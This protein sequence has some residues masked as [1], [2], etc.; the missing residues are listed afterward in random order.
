[1]ASPKLLN[2]ALV[3]LAALCFVAAPA[4]A[5]SGALRLTSLAVLASVRFSAPQS[6]APSNAQ[7]THPAHAPRSTSAF[8]PLENWKAAVL[9]GDSASLS[10]MYVAASGIF[11]KTPQ[12]TSDDP[13]EEP[14]FWSRFHSLGLTAIDAK[15][16]ERTTPQAGVIVLTMRVYLTFG[17]GPKATEMFVS[18]GQVWVQKDNAWYIFGSQRGDPVPRPILSLPE[19]ATPNTNLYP[20]PAEAPKDLAAA[21]AAAARDHKNVLVVFGGNWCFDCHV[22]DAAFHSPKIAPLVTANYHV[23]HINIGD[24]D[25]NMDIG[26]RY[27][28]PLK[29]GVP[30]VAVLDSKGK[31]LTSQQNREFESAVK[32]G[33]ADVTAFLER[34]KPGSASA[35]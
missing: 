5:S 28:V 34:W 32:I 22:L 33:P 29:K 1:M 30:A 12:G 7:E 10:S 17:S 6:S 20:A 23:V 18:L 2:S 21:L 35:N 4:F 27:N 31:L 3:L 13:H 19:P 24:Y 9:A 26:E 25:H 15:V 16:L 11:A 14:A 8:A